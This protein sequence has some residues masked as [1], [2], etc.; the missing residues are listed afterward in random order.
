MGN[1]SVASPAELGN[2]RS[3]VIPRTARF[4]YDHR[5]E[6][7]ELSLGNQKRRFTR[8]AAV[9]QEVNYLSVGCESGRWLLLPC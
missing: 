4:D 6:A 2:S 1:D 5:Q 7:N 3:G 9:C 8:S